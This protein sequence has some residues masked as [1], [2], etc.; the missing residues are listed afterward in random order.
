MDRTRHADSA[1]HRLCV[2]GLGKLGAPI[3]ACLASRGF[4][5]VAVDADPHKVEAIRDGR[6]PVYEPGLQELL[7]ETGGRLKATT[8]L[9]AAVAGSEITY[10]VVPTPSEPDGAFS[11]RH[12]LEACEAIGRGLRQPGYHLVVLTSTVM[13]GSTRGQVRLALEAASGKNC[14]RDFG[15]CYSPEFVALG[16]VVRDFLQPDFV[17]IGEFDSRAGDVLESVERRARRN[18]PP[19]ARTG[20]ESAE[21]AK[22]AVNTFITTKI[23]FANL[24][25]R[26]CET[27]PGADA[28]EVSAILGLDSRIGAKALRGAISYGGPCFPRDNRAL[29]RAAEIA[30]VPVDLPEAT[31]RFNRWQLGWLAER[32]ESLA[33]TGRTVG[34]LGLSYKP[35]SDVVEEAP[36]TWLAGELAG[37]GFSVVAFDP[38]ASGTAAAVLPTSVALAAAPAECVARADLVV[39]ATPWA[40]FRDIPPAVW[41]R[42]SQPRVVLDC[43]RLL[44]HLAGIDGVQYLPIGRAWG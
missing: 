11:L 24:L 26:L 36:G 38:A 44:P 27:L 12:V 2:V 33:R 15:L 23:T 18:D 39:V 21:L 29:A 25:A 13:P 4:S 32:V 22:L 17:L 5:V 31:D 10:I 34:V 19:I 16:T 9:E 8:D 30:G 42:H 14:G 20:L 43:W 6:A 7:A 37:R 40:E 1:P 28:G 35:G 41:A 3:A